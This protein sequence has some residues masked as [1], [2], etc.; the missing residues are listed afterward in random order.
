MYDI[1]DIFITIFSPSLH[2]HIISFCPSWETV[3]L[4]TLIYY[5]WN[6]S[7]FSSNSKRCNSS[8]TPLRLGISDDFALSIYMTREIYSSMLLFHS[9][10]SCSNKVRRYTVPYELGTLLTG[11]KK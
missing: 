10:V 8:I 1:A 7:S 3:L 5:V 2:L 9:Y 6:L 11:K 4:I